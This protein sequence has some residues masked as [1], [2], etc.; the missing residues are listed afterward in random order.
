MRY[1]CEIRKDT[2]LLRYEGEE[3]EAYLARRKFAQFKDAYLFYL[4]SVQ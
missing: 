4:G 1:V 2:I 3:K